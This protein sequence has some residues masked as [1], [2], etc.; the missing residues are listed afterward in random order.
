MNYLSRHEQWNSK[1]FRVVNSALCS[2]LAYL[3]ILFIGAGVKA[4]VGTFFNIKTL[5]YFFDS[6]PI[7]DIEN[8]WYL[9]S[10]VLV[11]SSG[12]IASIVVGLLGL[13]LFH[14][15][16]RLNFPFVIFFLWLYFWA[17]VV[18][19]SQGLLALLGLEEYQSP[20]FNNLVVVLAWLRVPKY[21][22]YFLAPVSVAFLILSCYFSTRPFISLAYS[23]GK[24]NKLRGRRKYFFETAVV[25][26]I[27]TALFV[28]ALIFPEKFTYVNLIYV[29]YGLLAMIIS[30]YLLYFL[31]ID[32]ESVFRNVGLQ[33]F[34]PF[35]VL[36]FCVVITLILW[37]LTTAIK[38]S[39]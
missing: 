26:F 5:L 28:T 36:L 6:I 29:L 7:E 9:R 35:I 24:V 8:P 13:S 19:S 2:I 38:I 16:K 39:L 21:L 25:P 32:R 20:Y 23:Y 14:V 37:K 3:T 11:Y 17:V 1:L 15:L 27:I 10:V 12:I 30:W 22:A 33:K 31:N 34:S 18:L 4:Y